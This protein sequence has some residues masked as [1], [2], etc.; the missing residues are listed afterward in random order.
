MTPPPRHILVVDI[1][2]T[3]AKL[4]LVDVAT[5]TE[6]AARTTPNRPLP[7]PPYPHADI[8]GLWSFLLAGI[9]ELNAGRRIDAIV[10]TTHGAAAALLDAAGELALPVLDYEHPGPDALAAAYD[11]ARPP[12]AETGTPRLPLGLNLGAQLFWQARAFPDAFARAATILPYP[13]Y[14]AFRL[15]GVAA[16]EATS[17]GCHTDLW[18]PAARAPSSL[19]VAEG[20]AA[21]LA[22]LR[23]AADRLG[24]VTPEVAA[25]TGLA[26]DTP[27]FCGIHDSNAS[28]LPH[29]LARPAP[30]A[31][32]STGTWVIAMAVGGRRVALDPARDT[33][34]NVDATGAP[35]PSARFMGG[36]EREI[37]AAGRAVEASPADLAAVLASGTMLLPALEPGSGPFQGRAAAW[38][39]EPATDGQRA[40]AV[41]LYL[42]LVTATCLDAI[43]AAGPTLVEGP[44]GANPAFLAM[45]A[46][47][48]ARPVLLPAA[49]GTGTS[50]GA[51]LLA[52]PDAR[53][54]A[55]RPTSLPADAAGLAAYAAAW[56]A[57]VA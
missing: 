36:R 37:A 29:L 5:L 28:L 41:S 15:S 34:M 26:P 9:A 11:A 18:N 42:A 7:G 51:A 12:F 50:V 43:G 10:V 16:S 32:V 53:P 48:T 6:T 25:A 35:V 1:G 13:Q 8:D 22:P 3:N 27:V 57:A 47:A 39:A 33:L 4:A 45:L 19:A 46:A 31:V 52:A 54:A 44:F 40:A 20:W 30:F 23:P 2:K 55:A 24:P 17:L 38:T 49:G 14:W 56:R 21:R